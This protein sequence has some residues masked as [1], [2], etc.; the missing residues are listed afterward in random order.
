MLTPRS[1]FLAGD[2]GVLASRDQGRSWHRVLE[3][4]VVSAGFESARLGFA[5]DDK[6]AM[7][8]TRDDGR[9]WERVDFRRTR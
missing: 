8:V 6:G 4:K 2:G 3:A 7:H 5:I 1:L 9:T